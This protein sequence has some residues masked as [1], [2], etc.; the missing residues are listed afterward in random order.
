MMVHVEPHLELR[1]REVA[2]AVSSRRRLGETLR[3]ARVPV[4]ERC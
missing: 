1:A 4:L 2:H 3:S